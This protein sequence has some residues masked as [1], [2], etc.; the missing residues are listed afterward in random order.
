MLHRYSGEQGSGM[1]AFISFKNRLFLQNCLGYFLCSSE[2]AYWQKFQQD[3]AEVPFFKLL[4]V[5]IKMPSQKRKKNEHHIKLC[6]VQYCGVHP[7]PTTTLQARDMDA[8]CGGDRKSQGSRK[9]LL[10]LHNMNRAWKSILGQRIS[11]HIAIDHPEAA[12]HTARSLIL[13][14]K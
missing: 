9:V 7:C 8:P 6:N 3:N 14:S 1:I 4:L 2:N 10:F 11:Q 5:A 12:G 13:Q